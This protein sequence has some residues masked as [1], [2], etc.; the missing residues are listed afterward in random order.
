MSGIS[1]QTAVTGKSPTIL[2]YVGADLTG[3]AVMKLP[4]VYG[5]R[6][7][8][9]S[10]HITWLAGKGATVYARE[11]APFVKG[12]IDE[13]VENAGIGSRV[14]ELFGPRPLA[15]RR[16]DIVIDTQRRV[17]TTLILRRI[18]HGC[19]VSGAARFLFSSKRPKDYAKPKSM[20]KQ[21][22]ALIA[23]A[24]G[25]SIELAAEAPVDMAAE[26]VA[27]RLLPAGPC[28]VGFAPGAGMNRKR[29]P[30]ERY[31]SVAKAGMD[32]GRVPVF[33]LGP[34]E[35]AAVEPIRAAIP[36]ALMPLQQV[37]EITPALTISLSRRLAAAVANDSGA[38]HLIAASGAPL[39]SLFGPTSPDKFAPVARRLVVVKAQD[40]G[41]EAMDAIPIEAVAK[42]LDRLINDGA[43]RAA[44]Q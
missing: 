20:V 14:S 7:E 31:I 26:G 15:G 4:F 10:A 22:A 43:A 12:S 18:E 19:F 21:L 11:M 24:S 25:R 41:S 1:G 40:W 33:L 38:G 16:F 3:D 28:Y 5:L 35:A 13:I 36:G 2:V 23:L 32:A 29:W 30:M 9:P 6:R 39:V 8:F 34:G 44:A 17:L 42:A 37:T 27:D